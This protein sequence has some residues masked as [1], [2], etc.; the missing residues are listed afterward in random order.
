V[1]SSGHALDRLRVNFRNHKGLMCKIYMTYVRSTGRIANLL[2]E[3]R[4]GITRYFP[5]G[6]LMFS[7]KT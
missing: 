1:I 7:L 2:V 4:C 3:I 6:G 5:H